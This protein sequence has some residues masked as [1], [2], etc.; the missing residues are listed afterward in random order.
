MGSKADF[1]KYVEKRLKE[2]KYAE[3][4]KQ[5]EADRYSMEAMYRNSLRGGVKR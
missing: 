1:M 5:V 2:K 3:R 4:R